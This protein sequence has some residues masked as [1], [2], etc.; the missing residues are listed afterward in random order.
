MKKFCVN[1]LFLIYRILI[2]EI[3]KQY[4]FSRFFSKVQANQ[5]HSLNFIFDCQI[6]F[7]FLRYK[8]SW[9]HQVSGK[10][11]VKTETKKK[12]SWFR[13]IITKRMK[14][15]ETHVIRARGIS[16]CA[17]VGLD[18]GLL[19]MA[20]WGDSHS[21]PLSQPLGLSHNRDIKKQTRVIFYNSFWR[22]RQFLF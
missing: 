7:S 22:Q 21:Y 15:D 9:S 3:N 18:K 11:F 8:V 14:R 2:K 17:S 10:A 19:G 13:N 1:F 5:T 4:K 12:R 20:L 6:F 16:I